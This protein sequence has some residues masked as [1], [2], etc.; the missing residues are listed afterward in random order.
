M[1]NIVP[2]WWPNHDPI[3]D[4]KLSYLENVERGPFMNGMP[5]L[6]RKFKPKDQWIEV[7]GHKG[8]LQL[9]NQNTFQ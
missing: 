7:F 2:Q 5:I 4:I 8:T 9:T 6:T 3:Y 1:E